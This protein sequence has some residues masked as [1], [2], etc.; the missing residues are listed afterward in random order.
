MHAACSILV[1]S[2]EYTKKTPKNRKPTY[3]IKSRNTPPQVEEMTKFEEDLLKVIENIE[4]RN[5]K[6]K[7]QSKLRN[8]VKSIKNSD[9]IFVPADKTNN[10]YKLSE[11][12][13]HKLVKDNTTAKYTRTNKNSTHEIN[14][15]AKVIAEQLELGDRIEILAEKPAFITIKRTSL[16]TL[17]AD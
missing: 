2:I 11:D 5:V 13:Y 7:F 6:C 3:G 1:E 12:E 4:F 17:N 16:I 10:Y 8:D 15:E 9:Q 14:N